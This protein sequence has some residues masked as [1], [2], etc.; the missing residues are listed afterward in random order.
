M[1]S[2]A[3]TVFW[4]MTSCAFICGTYVLARTCSLL[5]CYEDGVF[6]LLQHADGLLWRDTV[7]LLMAPTVRKKKPVSFVYTLNTEVA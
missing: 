7:V 5:L 3:L 4:Y 1:L 2:E 6:G